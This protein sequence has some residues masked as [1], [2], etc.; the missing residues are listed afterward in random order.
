VIFKIPVVILITLKKENMKLKAG[1]KVLVAEC[2][3]NDEV[4]ENIETSEIATVTE[5]AVG[6]NLVGIMY[7]SGVIDFVPQDILEVIKKLPTAIEQELKRNT[8]FNM[9]GLVNLSALRARTGTKLKDEDLKRRIQARFEREM[10]TGEVEF[11][12]KKNG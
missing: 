1:N 4:T 12:E 7:K 10:V 2:Y 6:D 11:M 5:D 3:R 9:M 8:L